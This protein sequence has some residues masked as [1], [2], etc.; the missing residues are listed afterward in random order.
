M[1]IGGVEIVVRRH[2]RVD[3]RQ[4]FILDQS[5]LVPAHLIGMPPNMEQHYGILSSRFS[6]R[7]LGH[8]ADVAKKYHARM[9][10]NFWQEVFI[11]ATKDGP[12]LTAAAA[13]TALDA[14]YKWTLPNGYLS[15]IGR[16]MK[17]TICGRISCVVTTPGTARFDVRAGGTVMFD[18]NAMNLNVVAK[19]TLP[20]I[21]EIW[22][23][24][25]AIGNGTIANAFGFGRFSS[26][27][28]VGSPLSTAGGNG[29]L[30]SSGGGGLGVTAVGAGFDSTPANAI[31]VFFTQTVATGSM[32]VQE[33]A[34]ESC[35]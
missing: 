15:I 26:E 3:P 28:V 6:D 27:A 31:D 22:F 14:S 11:T 4:K 1:R 30:C 17:L 20:F 29:V 25:R 24:M 5:V 32:T 19:V 16:R 35:N 9:S 10:G 33:Y 7:E 18:T 8:L 34:L 13:A 2:Q 12:A 21:M 23:T